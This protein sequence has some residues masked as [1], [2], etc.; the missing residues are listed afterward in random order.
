MCINLQHIMYNK[1]SD[2]HFQSDATLIDLFV[3]LFCGQP[4]GS[5]TSLACISVQFSTVKRALV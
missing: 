3:L 4:T 2:T 1:Q 5:I